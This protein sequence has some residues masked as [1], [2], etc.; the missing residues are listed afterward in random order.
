VRIVVDGLPY[1]II[2]SDGAPVEAAAIARHAC[3][4]AVVVS[5]RNVALRGEAVAD[6]LRRSGVT[7]LAALCVDAGERHKRWKGVSGLHTAF[8]ACGA[9]RSSLIIALGGG[10]LTDVVGFAAATFMRGL[11]WLAIP[12]TVLGMVDAAVGGKTG[13]DLPEGKNLIGAFWQPAGVVADLA[14]LETLPAADRRTGMAEIIKTAVACDASLVESAER[15]DIEQ[16]AADWARIIAQ[17]AAAKAQLVARDPFDRGVRAAL[18]LGHTFA[19]A[20]EHASSY[21]TSHGA[22]VALGL[23]AAGV[24]ARERTGWTHADHRRML[25]ALRRVGLR[26]RSP[27]LATQPILDA[28]R[29]DKKRRDGSVRF[30]LPVR[31]GEVVGPVEM[32]ES[33]VRQALATLQTPPVRGAW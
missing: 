27:A 23:R 30:V 26:V 22:A 8:L 2:V 14:S 4:T 19:H 15:L 13:V 31:L 5:D 21:R 10:T 24:L 9:E 6:A 3:A 1:P 32:P 11:P 28:M 29:S 33:A 20:I 12:T 17:A 18:N 25:R 16:P 7:V